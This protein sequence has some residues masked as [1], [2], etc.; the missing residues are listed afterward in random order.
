[1][2]IFSGM[3]FSKSH[4]NAIIEIGPIAFLHLPW[5]MAWTWAC[6]EDKCCRKIELVMYVHM[7]T[8]VNSVIMLEILCL[9]FVTK[10]L[11]KL[12]VLW[13]VWHR[14]WRRLLLLQGCIPGDFVSRLTK[15]GI[16]YH[17][18]VFIPNFLVVCI[19]VIQ[20]LVLV[21]N[22]GLDG[23]SHWTWPRWRGTWRI[24]NFQTLHFPQV[25]P[26][27]MLCQCRRNGLGIITIQSALVV[28]HVWCLH[29]C[30]ATLS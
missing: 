3:D 21:C 10:R 13:A 1:M 9:R 12:R 26:S 25:F 30:P 29:T 5:N 7:Y 4:K 6:A 20:R 24:S 15:I 17:S 16:Q 19:K 22:R 18:F 28:S 14:I 8:I 27:G 23:T 2:D 11:T